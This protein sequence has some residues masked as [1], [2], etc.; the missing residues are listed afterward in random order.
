MSPAIKSGAFVFARYF[1]TILLAESLFA[2]TNLLVLSNDLPIIT[3]KW[4]NGIFTWVNFGILLPFCNSLVQWK[5]IK[6]RG[7]FVQLLTA[8]QRAAS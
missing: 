8:V 4:Q 7:P 1:V 3:A 6:E 2:A 5:S